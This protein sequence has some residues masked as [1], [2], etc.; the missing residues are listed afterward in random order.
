MTPEG[1]KF[2]T[3]PSKQFIVRGS[4]ALGVVVIILVAQTAWFR[5]L[6]DKEPISPVVANVTVGDTLAKDTNE[7]GLPDWEERLWGLDPTVIYTN[8]VPNKTIIENKKSALGITT[9]SEENLNETDKLA[10]QL[11]SLTAALGQSEEVD[12]ATL[13]QIAADIGNSVDT[14][15]LRN[16]YSLKD[17]RTTTTTIENL[18]AYYMSM[19]TI[20]ARQKP[21][22]DIEVL[23]TAL[24][25]E[26][27]ST[28]PALNESAVTYKKIANELRGVTVPIGLAPYH[29]QIMNSFAGIAESFSYMQQLDDNTVIA[30][31]GVAT[32]KTYSTRLDNALADMSDY[33][34]KYGI[35][36]P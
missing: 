15:D 1:E 7:N 20:T 34:A 31:V 33:L 22:A 24:E 25:N 9:P 28:L 16:Q 2:T 26:D 23:I 12:D 8:G 32:Y 30:L 21:V 11:F 19:R 3:R 17:I 14:K 18:N 36:N 13:Q 5:S 6:F 10:R 27:S 29:L 35:L 4:I